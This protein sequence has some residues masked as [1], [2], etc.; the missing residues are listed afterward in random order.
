MNFTWGHWTAFRAWPMTPEGSQWIPKATQ[1]P[2]QVYP[3]HRGAAPRASRRMPRGSREACEGSLGTYGRRITETARASQGPG[4]PWRLS[5]FP[6]DLQGSVGVPIRK[7]GSTRNCHPQFAGLRLPPWNLCA[8]KPLVP[9][10]GSVYFA[11]GVWVIERCGCGAGG[12]W[13]GRGVR[14]KP[15]GRA[16]VC[17]T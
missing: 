4:D 6:R 11:V 13:Q 12:M 10:S 7:L 3:K 17:V 8:L 16:A 2:F 9:T 5:G 1:W 15:A 14:G